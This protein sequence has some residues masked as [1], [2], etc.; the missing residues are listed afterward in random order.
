MKFFKS[1][2]NQKRDETYHFHKPDNLLQEHS[3]SIGIVTFEKRFDDY[4]KP[5]LKSIKKILPEIE[6][7]VFIN[8]NLNN[9]FNN[10]YRKEILNYCASFDNVY[11]HVCTEFRSL[12]KL[13]NN[14]LIFSSNDQ[15]LILNDDV[16]L[17]NLFFD[18]LSYI[19]KIIKSLSQAIKIMDE[20]NKFLI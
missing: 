4:F 8:G 7:I 20:I 2:L 12:S 11:P 19:E 14:I 16:T 1:I 15:C 9:E 18:N 3:Y 5:L 6:I 13:W 10:K 17:T